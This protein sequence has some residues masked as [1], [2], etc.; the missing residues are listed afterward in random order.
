MDEEAV[1]GIVRYRV[2]PENAEEFRRQSKLTTEA[3]SRYPGYRGTRTI[4][5]SNADSDWIVIYSFDT[6]EHL[7]H[8]LSSD[9]RAERV[10][11]LDSLV[12]GE[13]QREHISGLDYWFAPKESHWPPSWRMTVVAFLAI[14]PLALFI[15]SRVEAL[16]P[17]QPFLGS[18]VAV[19]VVTLVMSYVSLPLMGW[20]FRRWL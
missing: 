5:P 20:L 1:T 8:W 2:A 19:A 14:L 9:I 6:C 7:D 15:P 10:R 4:E 3:C 16:F 12:I 18:V 11:V 13:G 17:T